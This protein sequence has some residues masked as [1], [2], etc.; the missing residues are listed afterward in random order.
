MSRLHMAA[1]LLRWATVADPPQQRL[2]DFGIVRGALQAPMT[3]DGTN[4]VECN[5]LSQQGGGGGVAQHLGPQRR[6][7]ETRSLEGSPDQ[8]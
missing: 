2:I 3:Q 7:P 6:R 8:R 4:D 1:R 5:T